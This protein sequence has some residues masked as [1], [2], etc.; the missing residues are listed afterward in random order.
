[1]RNTAASLTVGSP[2]EVAVTVTTPVLRG[3]AA[4]GMV[5]LTTMSVPTPAPRLKVL[6]ELTLAS[7]KAQLLKEW[8]EEGI[9]LSLKSLVDMEWDVKDSQ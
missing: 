9:D 8:E 1:M 7:N 3:G 5:T 4:S 2:C 6:A